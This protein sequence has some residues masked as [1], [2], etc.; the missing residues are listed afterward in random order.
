MLMSFPGRNNGALCRQH[1]IR[2]GIDVFLMVFLDNRNNGDPCAGTDIQFTDA[3]SDAFE[4]LLQPVPFDNQV[5]QGYLDGFQSFWFIGNSPDDSGDIPRFIIVQCNH[6]DALVRVV[7]FKVVQFTSAVIMDD[8]DQLI[9]AARLHHELFADSRQIRF[10]IIHEV[11]SSS[12]MSFS[13]SIIHGNKCKVLHIVSGIG[14][15]LPT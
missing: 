11:Q 1:H 9:A 3:V 12:W 10:S 5:V 4:V 7:I 8:H 6:G 13:S 15:Y 14:H 2:T